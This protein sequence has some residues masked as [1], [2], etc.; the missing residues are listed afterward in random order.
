MEE[1]LVEII[2]ENDEITWKDI[3]YDL[4]KSDQ[5]DP[6]DIDIAKLTKLFIDKLKNLKKFNF[7]VSGKAVLAAALLLKIKSNRLVGEDMDEFDRLLAS[8]DIN[9]E[10]FYDE[11]AAEMRDPSMISEE[12]KVTLIPRT[13]QPRSRKVSVYDLMNALEKALEVK[14]RRLIKSM[15]EEGIEIPAMQKD[16]SLSIKEVFK[17]IMDFFV[18]GGKKLTFRKLVENDHSKEERIG[19]FQPLLH[20]DYQ[21]KIELHQEKPFADIDIELLYKNKNKPI[22]E[23]DTVS[24][25]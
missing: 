2:V 22:V 6:W 8:K 15:P 12:E 11:L 5:M 7:K 3:I 25:E 4:V 21:R 1:K 20:L 18:T 24:Q 10:E 19:K 9:E 17:S 16:I 23:E 13:P 14:K